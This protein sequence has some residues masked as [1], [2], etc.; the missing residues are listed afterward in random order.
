MCLVLMSCK[1]VNKTTPLGVVKQP[2]VIE[3]EIKVDD[4]LNKSILNK[5]S[6][7]ELLLINK[8]DSTFQ[9]LYDIINNR[10]IILSDSDVVKYN[11]ITWGRFYTYFKY[12]VS[13]YDG[14]KNMTYD[15]LDSLFI[16]N[17]SLLKIKDKECYDFSILN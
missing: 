9:D 3:Y 11:E 7:E 16:K 1:E 12:Y 4:L 17:D 15:E 2:S 6:K 5:F 10:N 8:E 13:L 14:T